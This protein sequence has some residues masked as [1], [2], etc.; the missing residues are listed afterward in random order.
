MKTDEKTG[1]K[2]IIS[3]IAVNPFNPK[4]LAFG[5]YDKTIG[6][7]EDSDLTEICVLTGQ[8]GGL[9]HLEFS[10]DGNRLYSGGRKVVESR[11]QVFIIILWF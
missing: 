4:I 5:S 6:F 7:Y 2:G 1:Q 3:C 9:T 10:A 11:S 8:K